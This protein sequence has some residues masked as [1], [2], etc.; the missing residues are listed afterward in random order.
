[1]TDRF[2]DIVVRLKYGIIPIVLILTLFFGWHLKHLEFDSSSEGS[3]PRDDPSQ[4]YFEEVREDFGNDQV[5]VVVV[6]SRSPIGV[7]DPATLHKIDHLTDS[8]SMLEGV[9]NVVSLTNSRLLS[10]SEKDELTNDLII[11]EIPETTDSAKAVRQ[12]ILSNSL[13]HK[14]LVS[15]DGRAAAI[16][17]FLSDYPDS[18]LIQSGLDDLISGILDRHR[19]PEELFYD[20]LIHTRMAIN[21]TMQRDLT[22]FVPLAFGLIILILLFSLRSIRGVIIPAL[23]I[24]IAV[25]WTFGTIGLL[26]V[27]I[28][29]TMTIIPPLLMA[30]ACSMTIHM[31]SSYF[32]TAVELQDNRR[33][34]VRT[35]SSLFA[36]LGFAGF[37]TAVGFGALVVSPIPNI[38]KVGAFSVLGI[39][40]AMIVSFTF[41]PAMLSVVK[42]PHTKKAIRKTNDFVSI[43]IEKVIAVNLRYRKL[44]LILAVVVL[45]VSIIGLERIEVDTDYISYFKKGSEIRKT[46]EIISENL[47]G[48]FTFYVIATSDEPDAMRRHDALLSIDRLQQFMEQYSPVDKV[49]SMVNI[50][51]RYHQAMNSDEP[52]SFKIPSTQEALDEAILLTVDQE[53]PATRAHYVVEDYSSMA[54]FARSQLV[55]TTDL[56]NTISEIEEYARKV[57]PADIMV[58]ATGTVVVLAKSI[59]SIVHGQRDSLFIAF[60]I[61]FILIAIL[62][63]SIKIGLLPMFGNIVPIFVIFGIMGFT[64]I[65]LNIGT[66]IVAAICL[67]IAVDDTIH[68]LMRYRGELKSGLTRE[69]AVKS[70]LRAVGRPVIFTSVALCLGFM[71]LLFSDFGMLSSV[72]LLTGITMITCLIADLFITISIMLTFDFSEKLATG[73]QSNS[74][75]GTYKEH[76]STQVDGSSEAEHD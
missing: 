72:G 8:L 25:I 14:T 70:T 6:L 51:K 12:S 3:I 29:M 46:A 24:L 73:G 23:T 41:V 33:L 58:T 39:F 21:R 16:N 61:I 26:R 60:I 35:F 15:E 62:F 11:P 57:M 13:F 38:Q 55:S 66:S 53:E 2:F 75:Q 10:G 76:R 22:L 59:D 20:G 32:K 40:Y 71:V 1:L 44:I 74:D 27:P 69:E 48:V 50:V 49:T 45:L 18:I 54:L 19:G 7:F 63:R 28:N 9:D 68:I 31:V 52:D 65:T 4:Q 42:P 43:V 36:P 5:A 34:I 17:I 37:T 56:A 47:A 64:G 67:G 30:L